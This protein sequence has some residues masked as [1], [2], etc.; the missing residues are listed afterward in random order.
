MK[1][2]L[3]ALVLLTGCPAE[4]P[5]AVEPPPPPPPVDRGPEPLPEVAA[6][7]DTELDAFVDEVYRPILS[8]QCATCHQPRGVARHTRLHI[9]IS[10]ARRDHADTWQTAGAFAALQL[11]GESVLLLRATG[12]HPEGHPGGALIARGTRDYEALTTFVRE[13]VDPACN[14][15][16]PCTAY[17]APAIRR[18][19][20]HEYDRSIEALF[21]GTST[22]SAALASDLSSLLFDQ[23]RT[24]A[25]DVAFDV[26]IAAIAPCEATGADDTLCRDRFIDAVVSRIYRRPI[27]AEELD[28]YRTLFEATAD[29]DFDEGARW[30]I[31]AA[32]QSPHFVFRSE[33]G[34]SDGDLNRLNGDE[35]ATALAFFLTGAPPDEIL[36]TAARGGALATADERAR[37][38][39]RLFDAPAGRANAARFVT[40]WLDLERV[41]HVPKDPATYPGFTP[42]VRSSMLHETESFVVDRL[43][44]GATLPELLTA[45][46]TVPPDLASFYG[47][48]GPRFGLLTQGSLLSVHTRP[49]DASPVHR[50]KLVRTRL[51]CETL[52][53]PPPDLDIE[54]PSTD[55]NATTQERYAAHA[56]IEPCRSC[57]IRID[58]VGYGFN[59][60]D[61][62]GRWRATD[63]GKAVD[64]SG[65]IV[66]SANTDGTFDDMAGLATLLAASPDVHACFAE[67]LQ[68]WARGAE[69]NTC[70]KNEALAAF[71]MGAPIE[72]LVVAIA[73][74]AHFAVRTSTAP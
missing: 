49:N 1:R 59:A 64:A 53:G 54:P 31:V 45:P 24:H 73:S 60:Y 72:D 39:R 9:P 15:E 51:F 27:T 65:E 34:A 21:G 74:S 48:P 10:N 68:T 30:V 2:S 62:I 17:G 42:A 32:L 69:P 19:R 63:A 56:E 8:S 66:S 47:A 36:S 28:R 40:E 12:E 41:V 25:E 37:Q 50:G 55:P 3:L 16:G 29:D 38:A 6:P 44:A 23:L 26:D 67:R 20:P 22:R 13:A 71:E 5:T 14:R 4:V 70:A 43:A 46:T 52:P 35:I 7:C 33:L 11:D 61:G 57:H 18:L 58:P